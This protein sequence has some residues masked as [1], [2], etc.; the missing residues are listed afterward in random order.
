MMGLK[1]R[2]SWVNHCG[3]KQC[4]SL[5]WR[6]KA[7]VKKAVKKTN[8]GGGS[9]RGKQQSKFQYDPSSYALN[10]DDGC[11]DMGE[12]ASVTFDQKQQKKTD[13]KLHNS[14]KTTTLIYIIW[15]ES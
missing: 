8:V 13:S 11:Y 12:K 10:F 4:R 9:S 3:K 15:V 5:F 2:M 7:A 1:E 14:S 6:M